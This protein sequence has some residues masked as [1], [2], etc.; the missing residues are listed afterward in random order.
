MSAPDGKTNS[1]AILTLYIEDELLKCRVRT[2]DMHRLTQY[3]KIAV[4][5]NNEVTTANMIEKNG[6]YLSSLV[7][8]YNIDND[9]YCAIV[10]TEHENIPLVAGGS[11]AG[12][13]YNDTSVFEEKKDT[14][15]LEIVDEC[16]VEDNFDRCKNCKYKEFF[17][18]QDTLKIS[19]ESIEEDPIAPVPDST[20]PEAITNDNKQDILSSLVPQFDYIFEHY[21]E[22]IELSSL[23]PGSKF[24]SI[25]D[26][27][28]SYSVGAIYV[29]DKLK[30]L[31]YAKPTKYNSPVPV[32]LG[33]HYQW[34][35][36][37]K[38][39]P[40]SDG[41]YIVYQ[42]ATTLKILDL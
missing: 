7:G 12:Y 39:D 42:D 38:E 41:Y 11:Y 30:V 6:V 13:Y 27:E 5:H 25:Q 8:T 19:Q 23:L 36:L 22:N 16:P 17:Y 20:L 1:R 34:L 37:D 15:T 35:P 32:E 40:L 28:D 21:P 24:V 9:F 29:E 14:S 26:G 3:T 31:C 33:D 18:S 10:D 2:Y 4:Y